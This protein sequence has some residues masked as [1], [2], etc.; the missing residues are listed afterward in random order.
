MCGIGNILRAVDAKKA[1]IAHWGA[2]LALAILAIALGWL[3]LLNP[4]AAI[5]TAV[6]AI[7]GCLIFEG[8]TDL[9]TTLAVSKRI[10]AWKK[11]IQQ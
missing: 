8:V 11:T 6:A 4:F 1:G 5:E 2:L 3:I 10:D 7:G 9:F